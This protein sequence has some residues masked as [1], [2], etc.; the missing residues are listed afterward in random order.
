MMSG[1]HE[2]AF[3]PTFF[4]VQGPIVIMVPSQELGQLDPPKP[5]R[6]ADGKF[7]APYMLVSE[8]KYYAITSGDPLSSAGFLLGK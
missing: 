1:G 6:D 2:V 7:V 4:Q 3:F 8:A 5:L